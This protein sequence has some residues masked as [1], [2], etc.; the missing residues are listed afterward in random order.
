[1]SVGS[2]WHGLLLTAHS[3]STSNQ[4]C[5]QESLSMA[6]TIILSTFHWHHTR[7]FHFS[8]WSETAMSWV[9][10]FLE[11]RAIFSIRGNYLCQVAVAVLPQLRRHWPAE[12]VC[13]E[14][15]STPRLSAGRWWSL[16]AWK[17]KWPRADSYK[18]NREVTDSLKPGSKQITEGLCDDKLT[19]SLIPT[20]KWL[21]MITMWS[22]L[23]WFYF[24]QIHLNKTTTERKN[25]ICPCFNMSCKRL[26]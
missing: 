22:Q 6:Q 16:W 8:F 19:Y 18:N 25:Y 4:I 26:Q 20:Y 3:G 13:P 21:H 10:H 11:S 14:L 17:W 5:F 9:K 24:C 7:N 2:D 23:K 12:M 1:M 15:H